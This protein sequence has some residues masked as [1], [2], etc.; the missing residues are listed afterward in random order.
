MISYKVIKKRTNMNKSWIQ[1]N[2]EKQVVNPT[3][4]YIN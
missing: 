4:E 3:N 2:H 1:K